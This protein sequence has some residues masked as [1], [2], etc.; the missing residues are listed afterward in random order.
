V[1]DFIRG[2]SGSHWDGCDQVHWDCRI[3]KLEEEIEMYKTADELRRIA[4]ISFQAEVE[5][6]NSAIRENC[7][8]RMRIQELES[9]RDTQRELIGKS[10]EA[11]FGEYHDMR[12][13]NITLRLE[14]VEL[15]GQLKAALEDNSI[16][17][18]ELKEAEEDA[19][20]LAVNW[21]EG[22]DDIY[23]CVHCEREVT[24]IDN[25]SSYDYVCDNHT[26]DCPITLH[27]QRIQAQ[28]PPEDNNDDEELPY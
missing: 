12:K 8:L 22:D 28:D 10:A 7:N 20:R 21:Y 24:Q 15:G 13:E 18:S 1:S 27:N 14:L 16:L 23:H 4:C 3:A 19:E 25:G 2:G 26:P 11:I 17:Q 5:K 9:E 6:G